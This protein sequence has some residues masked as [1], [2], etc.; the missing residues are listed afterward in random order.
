M[1]IYQNLVVNI[2]ND[3]PKSIHLTD[4]PIFNKELS[5]QIQMLRK[6]TDYTKCKSNRVL[7]HDD[8]SGRFSSK[9]FQDVF[10]EIEEI[11]GNFTKYL[12][13]IVNADTLDVQLSEIAVLTTTNNAFL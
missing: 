4:F 3:A 8:I 7:I 12:V 5:K 2:N 13:Q 6:L 9:G 1:K 11:D 10:T